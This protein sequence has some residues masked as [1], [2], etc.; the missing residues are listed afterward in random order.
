MEAVPRA[1]EE[2]RSPYEHAM[3]VHRRLRRLVLFYEGLI[4]V[5]ITLSCCASSAFADVSVTPTAPPGSNGLQDLVNWAGYG[6]ALACLGG[7][8]YGFGKMGL[9]HKDGS[10]G[11]SN[12]GKAVGFMSLLGALGLGLAPT[13]VNTLTAIH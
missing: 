12:H 5:V 13:V 2:S 7:A 8:I 4:A 1:L 9:S 6:G 10:Y 3:R 11:A